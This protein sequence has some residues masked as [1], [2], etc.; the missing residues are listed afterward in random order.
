MHCYGGFCLGIEKWEDV[1]IGKKWE[2]GKNGKKWKIPEATDV[3]DLHEYFTQKYIYFNF[4]NLIFKTNFTRPT[5]KLYILKEI[6]NNC[7]YI[8]H[9]R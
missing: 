6:L 2:D 8:H 7:Q 3:M 4:I 9:Q 1:K 5:Q